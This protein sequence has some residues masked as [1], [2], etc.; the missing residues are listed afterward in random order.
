MTARISAEANLLERIHLF[1]TDWQQGSGNLKKFIRDCQ[2]LREVRP[3]VWTKRVALAYVELL[4]DIKDRP[5]PAR[6]EESSVTRCRSIRNGYAQ[7]VPEC[8][9][10][11]DLTKASD[12]RPL[13]TVRNIP[14]VMEFLSNLKC[15][16]NAPRPVENRYYT[17][18]V[19]D[20]RPKS[21]VL[22]ASREWDSIHDHQI[23]QSNA[24]HNDCD[25][26][27]WSQQS[28][29]P[30]SE[31]GD[32]TTVLTSTTQSLGERNNA[33]EAMLYQ[34]RPTDHYVR[35][36]LPTAAHR[37]KDTVETAPQNGRRLSGRNL[38]EISRAYG[39]DFMQTR[40]GI[41]NMKC[42]DAWIPGHE[43]DELCSTL[44]HGLEDQLTS[45][46]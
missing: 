14:E 29:R 45:R 31:Q 41:K 10:Y 5:A 43:C 13:D 20:G 8:S 34:Q 46:G 18:T 26:S 17:G 6:R 38:D 40:Q 44:L 16:H 24:M 12:E 4:T 7:S 9:I 21:V 36:E 33:W 2:Q 30:S 1:R 27:S 3:E 22:G 19:D 32:V 25:H 42:P 11:F 23:V 37:Q 15:S 39:S 35:S 28:T